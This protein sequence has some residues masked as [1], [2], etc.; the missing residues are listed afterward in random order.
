MSNSLKKLTKKQ[1][2]IQ[3][4]V[5]LML[6]II[7]MF[8]SFIICKWLGISNYVI[9][10]GFSSIFSPLTSEVIIWFILIAIDIMFVHCF[11]DKKWLD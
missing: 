10:Y 11:L 4:I 3:T 7:N 6:L 2:T 8:I 1:R 9:G 5:I